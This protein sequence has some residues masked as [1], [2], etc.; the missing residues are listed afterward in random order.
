VFSVS[1]DAI[2]VTP[3]LSVVLKRGVVTGG[4]VDVAL[5]DEELLELREGPG[6]H[7]DFL[8]ASAGQSHAR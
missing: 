6:V 7:E 5:W 8:L 4:I 2:G 1:H 3:C